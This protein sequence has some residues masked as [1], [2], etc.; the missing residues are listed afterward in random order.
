MRA[1]SLLLLPL[2][3]LAPSGPA[4]GAEGGAAGKVAKGGVF[5]E[6]ADASDEEAK[7]MLA[8]LRSAVAAKEEPKVVEAVSAMV[9]KRH[10]DFVPELKKLLADRRDAV[11]SEAAYALGSQG[12]KTA[13][14]ILSKLLAADTRNKEGY[15]RDPLTRA[16]VV[17]AL[18]RLGD[19]KSVAR[20]R[21]LAVSLRMAPEVSARYARHIVRACVRFFGLLKD[22]EA[23]SYLI[24]EVD[25]PAPKDP[26]SNTNPG[27]DYWKARYDIWVEIRPEVIWALKEITG[28]EMETTRRWENWFKEEGR[29]AGFK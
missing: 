4:A 18:G 1:T 9:G 21:D 23:V 28:K 2:A 3:F 17:E 29:K 24:D 15:Y 12:D 8:A 25:Q 27:A 11:S 26:N 16:A 6:D 14:G 7:V 22:R 13:T 5:P 10:K 19:A 20:V